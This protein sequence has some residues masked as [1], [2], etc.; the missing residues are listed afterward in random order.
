MGAVSDTALVSSDPDLRTAV[1]TF[2]AAAKSDKQL[3]TQ[4]SYA[5][6]LGRI[7]HELGPHRPLAGVRSAEISLVL[8][9]AWGSTAPT[10]WNHRRRIVRAWLNW[11]RQDKAWS[12]PEF[13]ADLM[14]R[15]EDAAANRASAR[16]HIDELLIRPDLPLRERT[17]WWMLYESKAR[18]STVLALNIEDLDLARRRASTHLSS[19]KAPWIQWGASTD[20]LLPQFIGH[21]TVGPLFLTTR[22]RKSL[23]LDEVA[24][25][26]IDSESGRLRL[27]YAG[28]REALLK[29]S[30]TLH[31][32]HFRLASPHRPGVSE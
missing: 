23:Y 28:A 6:V 17:L 21:R 4:H 26:D 10:T 16:S 25:R 2:L 7:V 31:L 5:S 1:D 20:R 18:T 15:Q 32:A 24:D 13:P 27:G 3:N 12:A 29:Y 8:A 19:D 14:R 22:P 9:Q 30:P 11:C